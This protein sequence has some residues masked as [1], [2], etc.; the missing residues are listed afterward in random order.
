MVV[1]IIVM[2]L[3]MMCKISVFVVIF[4]AHSN[5]LQV[6]NRIGEHSNRGEHT[7]YNKPSTLIWV[8]VQFAKV[9]LSLVSIIRLMVLVLKLPNYRYSERY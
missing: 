8:F 5:Q 3:L 4:M 9:L 2:P 6:F 7:G 1:F